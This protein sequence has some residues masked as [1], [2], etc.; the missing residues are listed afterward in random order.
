[1]P[2]DRQ[3]GRRAYDSPNVVDLGSL[4]DITQAHDLFF[5]SAM[6]HAN[7]MAMSN[8]VGGGTSTPTSGVAGVTSTNTPGA[9]GGAEPGAA[10]GVGAAGG[11]SGGGG[12]AGAGHGELPFTG[13]SLTTVAALGSALSAAGVA[14]RRAVSGFRR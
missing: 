8:P 12:G 2:P 5:G 6:S 10:G 1:M 3:K 11:A 4:T 9:P 7:N 13:Y 14:L